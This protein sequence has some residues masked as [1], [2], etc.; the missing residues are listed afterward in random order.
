MEPTIIVAIISSICA[1]AVA[2]VSAIRAARANREL[3]QYRYELQTMQ[4]REKITRELLEK[5]ADIIGKACTIIQKLRDELRRIKMSKDRDYQSIEEII[6]TAKQLQ[7][8]Y[9]QNHFVVAPLDREIL[10]DA[11]N[12]AGMIEFDLIHRREAKSSEVPRV[13]EQNIEAH[14]DALNTAQRTLLHEYD[15]LQ[16]LLTQLPKPIREGKYQPIL[17]VKDLR[18]IAYSEETKKTGNLDERKMTDSQQQSTP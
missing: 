1:I 4:E 14:L 7:A 9:V 15:K 8:L 2:L 18:W 5:R 12:I 13:V 17:S 6:E 11:K 10:H 16:E 3:E